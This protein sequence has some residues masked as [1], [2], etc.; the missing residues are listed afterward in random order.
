LVLTRSP[1]FF[2]I[3]EGATTVQS[4]PSPLNSL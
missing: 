1:A 4:W 3:N 2:G